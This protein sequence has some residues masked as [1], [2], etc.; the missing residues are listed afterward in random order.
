[1]VNGRRMRAVFRTNSSLVS[2]K[3]LCPPYRICSISFVIHVCML[4]LRQSTLSLSQKIFF[5]N[6]SCSA[7]LSMGTFADALG[8]RRY[9]LAC[10][11]L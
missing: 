10:R 8:G 11:G 3:T 6:F 9:H 1:M 2:F 4:I 7:P 5:V